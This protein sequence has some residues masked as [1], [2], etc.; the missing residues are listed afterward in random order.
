M[1]VD[2]QACIID[3]YRRSVRCGNQRRT[4]VVSF[5]LA[6]AKTE[7]WQVP[8]E[9]EALRITFNRECKFRILAPAGMHWH[10]YTCLRRYVPTE[11]C[12]HYARFAGVYLYLL[13]FSPPSP[14]ST[15]LLAT[16]DIR[17]LDALA[18]L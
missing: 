9:V 17:A 2:P 3:A 4:G 1:L 15:Y 18:F 13:L 10:V 7:K 14:P 11:D 8:F 12:S 6:S 16:A 5:L